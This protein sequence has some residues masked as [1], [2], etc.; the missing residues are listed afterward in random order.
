MKLTVKIAALAAIL[1][2]AGV[3]AA[4]PQGAAAAPQQLAWNGPADNDRGP[5][6][7]DDEGPGNHHFRGPGMHR[8]GMHG[9]PLMHELHRLN[10][11]D[12]QS[13][14]VDA[15]MVKHHAEQRDLFKRRRD[16]HRGFAALDPTATD[17]ASQ[18]SKLADQ[19]G[20]LAHD[21]VLLR[22]RIAGE[23]IATL[24][25]EQVQQLKADR[26]EH[27]ARREQHRRGP[28]ADDAG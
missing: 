7:G 11:S 24:T 28:A 27:E 17:Y 10:L 19:T 8:G 22:S 21:E 4:T 6:P 9:S 14:A 5:P 13:D 15:I 2:A 3:Q 16:L 23:V 18:S 25:P 20:K 26:A 12:A 1:A